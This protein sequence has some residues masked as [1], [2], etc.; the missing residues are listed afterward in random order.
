MNKISFN[1]KYIL[2]I[3]ILTLSMMLIFSTTVF[4]TSAKL[5]KKGY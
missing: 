3:T 5:V 2:K 4:A 1:K